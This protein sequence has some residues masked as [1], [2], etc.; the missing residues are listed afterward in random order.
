MWKHAAEVFADQDGVATL[1][2]L[3]AVGVTDLM[4]SSRLASGE[5]I[6]VARGLFR[7]THHP[8]TD[9]TGVRIGVLLAGGAA[10]RRTALFWHGLLDEPPGE[11]TVTVPTERRLRSCAGYRIETRRRWLDP[12]DVT[13]VGGLSVTRKPLSVLEVCDAR[14]MDR[15][16]QQQAVTLADLEAALGRNAGARGIC[17]AREV[18]AVAAG[19]TESEAERLFVEL[20]RLH[21]ITG[22]TAQAPFRGWSID[23]AFPESRLAVEI[24][25]WAFHRSRSRWMRDQ[26]KSN[27]LSSAGWSVLNFSWHHLAE[28]PEGV[29]TTLAET[30]AGRAA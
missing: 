12:A 30:L 3:R 24:N 15:A 11:I 23:F 13:E 14:I 16:L 10:D 25:G 8:H 6:R 2:Q 27:A 4:I 19:D 5:L 26:D 17:R 20:L 18:F 7:T 1:A 21:G 9:R 29:I 28:D 22:W